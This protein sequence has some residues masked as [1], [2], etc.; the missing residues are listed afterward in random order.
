MRLLW[1]L[2]NNVTLK[3]AIL[4]GTAMFGTLDTW[5][6]YRLT[7][8]KS[9]CTDYSAAS[10][11]GMYDPFALSWT[12]FLKLFGIP[13]WI[14]PPVYDSIGS[15]FGNVSADIWGSEIPIMCSVGIFFFNLEVNSLLLIYLIVE[16]CRWLISL[17]LRSVYAV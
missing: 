1:A 3:A 14:L 16:F 7:K 6:I 10:A 11:T 4:N 17:L 2:Q 13:N 9:Y 5:L 8:G 12:F 15:H